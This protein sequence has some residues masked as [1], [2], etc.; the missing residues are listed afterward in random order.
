M[1]DHYPCRR[2]T[3]AGRLLGCSLQGPQS[4][5]RTQR[6]PRIGKHRPAF[7]DGPVPSSCFIHRTSF[8]PFGTALYFP[9]P[10]LPRSEMFALSVPPGVAGG[11]PGTARI[12]PPARIPASAPVG[13]S[14]GNA[15]GVGSI[16]ARVVWFVPWSGSLVRPPIARFWGV[17]RL[18]VYTI[19]GFLGNSRFVFV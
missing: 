14:A 7:L 8:L 13:T 17:A 18:A 3:P 9:Q 1:P 16:G 15:C 2:N 11:G 12:R 4:F 10:T 5:D 6:L 19:R